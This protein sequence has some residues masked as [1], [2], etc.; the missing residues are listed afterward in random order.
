MQAKLSNVK[1]SNLV[2]NTPLDM[3]QFNKTVL[4]HTETVLY[5]ETSS[6]CFTLSCEFI[7]HSFEGVLE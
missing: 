2:G 7:V 1:E 6:A 4:A 3:E 5:L